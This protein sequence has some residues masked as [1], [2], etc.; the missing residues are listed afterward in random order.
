MTQKQVSGDLLE[1]SEFYVSIV[2]LGTLSLK[3][4]LPLRRIQIRGFVYQLA[5]HPIL[6][7]VLVDDQFKKIPLSVWRLHFAH[8]ITIARDILPGSFPETRRLRVLHS[9]FGGRLF[10]GDEFTLDLEAGAFDQPD[11]SGA[12]LD[13]LEL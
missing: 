10:A 1:R 3:K 5:V 6:H 7:V 2:D 8:R 11:V 13:N 4:K 9:V 12:A